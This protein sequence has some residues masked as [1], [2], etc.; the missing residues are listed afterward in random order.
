VF[1]PQHRQ[2][3]NSLCDVGNLDRVDETHAVRPICSCGVSKLSIEHYLDVYKHLRGLNYAACARPIPTVSVRVRCARW[4]HLQCFYVARCR[5]NVSRSGAAAFSAGYI[6]GL[7]R[8]RAMTT[9][10]LF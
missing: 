3:G 7:N 1:P 9:A 6:L 10:D 8:A 4:V 5:A 2:T